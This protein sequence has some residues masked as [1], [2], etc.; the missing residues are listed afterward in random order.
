MH[1][2]PDFSTLFWPGV[3]FALY[4]VLL[5][6]LYRRYVPP[7][8]KA[9]SI[10]IASDLKKSAAELALAQEELALL[11]KRLQSIGQEKRELTERFEEEAK[12]F[13]TLILEEAK[14]RA[15]RLQQ[16]TVRQIE[17]ELD[18]ARKDIRREIIARAV[19]LARREIQGSLSVEEDR[20]LRRGLLQ[21]SMFNQGL[22]QL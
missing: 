8:L 3:N 10:Q 11:N 15:E 1:S 13:A 16:D 17:R 7:L 21:P 6:Y 20:R 4:L 14:D 19:V 5:V 9:R 12:N 18:R 22:N 2:S